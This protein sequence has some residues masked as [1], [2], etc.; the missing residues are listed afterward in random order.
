MKKKKTVIGVVAVCVC[1]AIAAGILIGFL[2]KGGSDGNQF[3]ETEIGDMLTAKNAYSVVISENAT[4]TEQY[5][6]AEIASYYERVSGKKMEV[7][8]DGGLFLSET[9]SYISLGDTK[10]YEQ[11]EKKHGTVDLSAEALNTDGFAIFTYGNNVLI[12]GYN[13]R[14][15][16]YGAFEFIEHTLGVKFLTYDYTHVPS[17]D[18]IILNS[19]DKVYKPAFQQRAYLNTSVFSNKYEYVA[20]M[21]FNTD[22]CFMPENMGGTTSWHDFGNPSHTFPAIVSAF[23][24]LGED[25][26]ITTDY[27]DS[28]AHT[29]SGSEMKTYKAMDG[30]GEVAAENS[31]F[32]LVTDSLKSLISEDETS[33]WYMLGQADRPNGCPCER[34]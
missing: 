20:H 25:G 8:T 26:Q 19:Y 3:T 14:G 1:V 31:A 21:R 10:I 7:V 9:S 12:N 6:A 29:G 2:G 32:R 22:Y 24:Y 33:E 4:A 34:C 13:D 18:K 27:R 30:T 17:S 5:A 11:A 15:V 16:M 23:D 28:F